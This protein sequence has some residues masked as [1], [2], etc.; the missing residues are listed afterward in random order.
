M[1]VGIFIISIATTV[2]AVISVIRFFMDIDLRIKMEQ[3]RLDSHRAHQEYMKIMEVYRGR[4]SEQG[5]Q[6]S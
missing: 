5:Q 6:G 1:L 4:K 2:S 3:L